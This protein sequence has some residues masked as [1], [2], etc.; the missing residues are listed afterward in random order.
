MIVAD[1]IEAEPLFG[2]LYFMTG[3]VRRVF[4]ALPPLVV[5]LE[6]AD[7]H[8]FLR[9][10][11]GADIL[12]DLAQVAGDVLNLVAAKARDPGLGLERRGGETHL[13]DE[14][15]PVALC[16]Q[17]FEIPLIAGAGL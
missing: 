2:V 4:A 3:G 11:C 17:L 9:S 14:D 16:G 8:E 6:K 15:R 13:G 10:L 7:P 1:A 12:P 5:Q